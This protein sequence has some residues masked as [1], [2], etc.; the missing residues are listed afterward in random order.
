MKRFTVLFAASVLAV[1]VGY[2]ASCSTKSDESQAAISI[3][4][5]SDVDPSVKFQVAGFL[6]DY[7]AVNEMLIEDSLGGAK[8][9]A[10]AFSQTA[11]NFNI[12]KLNP[13]QLDFYLVHSSDLKTSLESLE[14]SNDIES[15]R[16]DLATISEA[17]YA[18]VKAFHPNDAP[19]YYQY[20]PMARDNKGANWLSNTKELVNPYMGQMMLACGRT[21]ETIK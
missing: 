11:K 4:A 1:F 17:M 3:S 18:M 7:F 2:L 13:E 16:V 15:A 20:C 19:L 5:F 21:Q 8:L 6:T 10:A 14:K 12:E 9:A